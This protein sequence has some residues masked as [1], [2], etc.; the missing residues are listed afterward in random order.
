MNM[1]VTIRRLMS[2]F[3]LLFLLISGV[4]AYVQVSNQAFLGG[5][6]LAQGDYDPR[7]CPPF[8]APLRGKILDRNGVVL[9]ESVK[10]TPRPVAIGASITIPHFRRSSATSAIVSGP[11][12]SRAPITPR[13][14]V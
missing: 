14:R 2:V 10:D 8:D 13:S 12:A 9:A 11:L 3:T 4:A 7:R 5:P 1:N 6:V